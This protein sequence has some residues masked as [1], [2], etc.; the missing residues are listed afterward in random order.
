M[1]S[2]ESGVE[3]KNKNNLKSYFKKIKSINL[4]NIDLGGLTPFDQLDKEMNN[5]FD[6]NN[7]E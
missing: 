7:L 1:K 2:P 5:V 6:R 4:R 3:L